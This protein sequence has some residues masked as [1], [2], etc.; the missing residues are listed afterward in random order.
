[1]N[2]D[3]RDKSGSLSRRNFLKGIGTS[4]VA[5]AATQ[6]EAIAEQL[7]AVNNEKIHGPDKTSVTLKIDGSPETL[8]LEPRVT[9]LEA[10]RE[11]LNHTGPKEVCDR[12]TCGACTVLL[13]GEPVYS[14]MTLA[15]ETQGKEITTVEGLTPGRE[16]N[17]VQQA[18]VETDA[19]MCGY[20][21]PGFVV[22]L[23]SLLK[24]NPTP[25]EG[26]VREACSGNLCR[27]GTYPRIFEAALKA[28]GVATASKTEVISFR[29]A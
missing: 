1:M 13:D 23:T 8:E 29:D 24:K 22:N 7:E 15:I 11:H 3:N 4:T 5:A 16:L 26:E 21:T 10:L 19:L 17:R 12:G 6:A 20:C 28:A 27:C 2:N 9:L 18:F 14:C 25:T